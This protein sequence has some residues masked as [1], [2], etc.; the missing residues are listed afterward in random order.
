MHRVSVLSTGQSFERIGRTLGED[1]FL[2]HL[3]GFGPCCG[4]GLRRTLRRHFTSLKHGGNDLQQLLIGEQGTNRLVESHLALL[5]FRAVALDAVLREELLQFGF[6]AENHW[7]E[8][9]Q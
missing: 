6:R 2:N 1:L 5:F 9:A 4:R 8:K 7:Q 3:Q